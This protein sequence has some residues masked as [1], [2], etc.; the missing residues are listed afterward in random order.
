MKVFKGAFVLGMLLSLLMVFGC[1]MTSGQRVQLLENAIVQA[2]KVSDEL[3]VRLVEMEGVLADT[4]AAL[5]D[6]NLPPDV[7]EQLNNVLT[8]TIE[9]VKVISAKRGE[10]TGLISRLREQIEV[11]KKD[12]MGFG[13]ELKLWGEGLQTTGKYLPPPVGGYVTLAGVIFGAVGTVF[14]R[15]RKGELV[16]V[17]KSV[18]KLL[19]SDAVSD[20]KAATKI[21]KD[22]QLPNTRTAV[23]KIKGK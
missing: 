20:T 13:D 10:Y 22:N 18:D 3:G 23:I 4:Q 14:A 1:D 19:E 6:Q 12:G 17:V 16:G 7:R 11:A 9:G 8:Q 15:R 5:G 2:E 21:L